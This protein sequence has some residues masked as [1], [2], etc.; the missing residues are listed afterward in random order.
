MTANIL[1]RLTIECSPKQLYKALTTQQG[2]S[3]W[4]AHC[5]TNGKLHSTASFFF[6]A[7]KDHKIVMKITELIENEK[8]VWKCI[9]GPWEN[10]GNFEFAIQP[11]QRGCVLMFSHHDWPA[12]DEFF[13]HCNSKWGY[14]FTVSLKNYLETGKGQPNPLDPNI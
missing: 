12:A 10:T 5:E 14:F 11:D 9:E 3:A 6:G 1:H 2:L 4:W 7:N 8:I 13:M